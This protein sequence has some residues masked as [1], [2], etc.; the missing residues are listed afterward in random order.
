[1]G[2]VISD[3]ETTNDETNCEKLN[4][5]PREKQQEFE[6]NRIKVYQ[7]G[8]KLFAK[9]DGDEQADKTKNGKQSK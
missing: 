3:T 6:G 4:F 1:M 9:I 7:C 2:N 5:D 8:E